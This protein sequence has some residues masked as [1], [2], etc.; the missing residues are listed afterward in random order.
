MTT[1]VCSQRTVSERLDLSVFTK[2]QLSYKCRLLLSN[3][4]FVFHITFFSCLY[5]FP[6]AHTHRL[7]I[8]VGAQLPGKHYFVLSGLSRDRSK[9][10]TH[11]P[12][13]HTHTHT[14]SHTY[15]YAHVHKMPMLA[16]RPSLP[17]SC[18]K[19]ICPFL[20]EL[21]SALLWLHPEKKTSSSYFLLSPS[22]MYSIS[23][24]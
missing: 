19:Q 5:C 2:K 22:E 12:N 3:H 7:H 16:R 15:K 14:H 13:T 17:A 11:K 20:T 4:Q 9:L 10:N 21:R 24:D 18:V 8:L 6:L 23:I 1:T